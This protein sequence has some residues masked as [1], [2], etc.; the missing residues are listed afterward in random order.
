MQ[1]AEEKE[2]FKNLKQCIRNNSRFKN[3]KLKIKINKFI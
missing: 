3:F 1:I 2:T